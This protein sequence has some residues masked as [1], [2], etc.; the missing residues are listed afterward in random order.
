M[1]KRK[2]K[3]RGSQYLWVLTVCQDTMLGTLKT[4]FSRVYFHIYLNTEVSWPPFEE[5][6][7]TKLLKNHKAALW[8]SGFEP[9]ST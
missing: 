9:L 7:K 8:Q 3:K 1:N 2:E 4:T 6:E 5:F